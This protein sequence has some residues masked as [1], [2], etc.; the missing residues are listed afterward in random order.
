MQKLTRIQTS[1]GSI[2]TKFFRGSIFLT[3][4]VAKLFF[5]NYRSWVRCNYKHLGSDEMN[6]EFFCKSISYNLRFI[7]IEVLP[8]LLVH[9]PTTF[10]TTNCALSWLS[11]KKGSQAGGQ[12]RILS[13]DH[14]LALL[15]DAPLFILA[16]SS[17]CT[18]PCQPQTHINTLLTEFY[19]TCQWNW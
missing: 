17:W 6:E 11:W 8:M 19:H 15:Q 13:A 9:V 3:T 7:E 12:L 16:Y 10:Q 4:Q 18:L 1:G 2:F 14:E 5:F